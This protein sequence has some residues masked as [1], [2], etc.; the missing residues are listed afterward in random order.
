MNKILLKM[1]LLYDE[2]GRAERRIADYLLSSPPDRLPLTISELAA[3]C[4]SSVATI[5]RF[6]RRLGCAGYQEL[7]LS[8]VKE[9]VTETA[10]PRIDEADSCYEI[11]VKICNDAYLSLE[12]TQKTISRDNL[13]LASDAIAGA[14]KVVLVGLGSSAAVA[15]DMANKLLRAGCDA[16]TY[17]DTHMQTIAISFLGQRDV[18]VGISHSGASKDIVEALKAARQNG[19]TTICITGTEKSPILRQADISL[20]TDTEEQRHSVL[21]LSSHFS[22]LMVIDAICYHVVSRNQALRERYLAEN[23]DSLASKRVSE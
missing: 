14:R 21:S 19:A 1:Q 6:S 10:S 11:F 9:T 20:I 22:R 16:N 8:L 18:L 23:D 2:M 5:V 13:T 7:K 4:G 17:A 15:V 3:V 12:R